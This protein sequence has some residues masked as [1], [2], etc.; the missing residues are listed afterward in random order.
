[1]STSPP[2]KLLQLWRTRRGDEPNHLHE[3][4][5]GEATAALV[6]DE[7][8]SDELLERIFAADVVLVW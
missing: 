8:A 7:V 3:A 1:V 6:F 5:A 4:P 2:R